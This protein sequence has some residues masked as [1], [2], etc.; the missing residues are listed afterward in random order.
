VFSAAAALQTW[1]GA[2]AARSRTFAMCLERMGALL[3]VRLMWI[4]LSRC[5]IGTFAV[6]ASRS[7]QLI[8]S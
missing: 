3:P 7:R 8:D 2:S 5:R 1:D 6:A 4:E